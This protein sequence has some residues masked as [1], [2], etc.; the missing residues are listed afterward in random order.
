M[1]LEALQSALRERN[2]DGWLFYDHHHRDAIAYRVLGLPEKLMVTRRWFYLIPAEGEP[3][4][5]VHKIESAHLDSLPGTKQSYA[6]W[7][8]LFD[9]IKQMLS[10]SRDIA[11]QYSP[12][13]G[14][15]TLSLV[16]GG[17]IELIRATWLPC[18]K[19]P[20]RTSRSKAIS[21]PATPLTRLRRRHFRRSAAGRAAAA[22][23]N[24]TCSNGS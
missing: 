11:M 1:N 14:V 8:E 13:N 3:R 18:S 12:N 4:K 19:P 9:G 24:M 7:P 16:D 21:R 20:G 6:A 2:L 23:M 5:L 15:F 22:P 17:T 10:A